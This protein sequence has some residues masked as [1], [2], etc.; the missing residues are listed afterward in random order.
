MKS[1]DFNYCPRCGKPL[2][3]ANTIP[4]VCA[5]DHC[6][7][8]IWLNPIPVVAVLCQTPAGIV[9][10]HNRDWPADIYGAI[11]GFIEHGEDP[12]QAA[13]RDTREELGLEITDISLLGAYNYPKMNQTIIAYHA[14]STSKIILGPELDRYK[15]IPLNKLKPWPF[16]TGFAVADLLKRHSIRA[17]NN[18]CISDKP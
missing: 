13:V 3:A 16:G 15:E 18:S 9:L 1:D 12:E 14:R 7:Y 5:N 8:Q 6:R 2:K 11:T 17:G 10:A 4:I